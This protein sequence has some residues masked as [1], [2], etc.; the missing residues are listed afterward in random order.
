MQQQ[1]V[2][3][4]STRIKAAVLLAYKNHKMMLPQYCADPHMPT[5]RALMSV[6]HRTCILESRSRSVTVSFSTVS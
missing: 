4:L 6:G 5:L 1:I 3:E 2:L